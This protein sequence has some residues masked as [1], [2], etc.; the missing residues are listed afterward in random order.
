LV[1]EALI[2]AVKKAVPEAEI[3]VQAIPAE[4][5]ALA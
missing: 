4:T 1:T 5:T 3:S 2:E